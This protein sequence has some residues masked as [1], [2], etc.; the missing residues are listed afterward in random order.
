MAY[1]KSEKSILIWGLIKVCL[2][3]IMIAHL[4]AGFILAMSRIDL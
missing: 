3:N 4:M 2:S 1:L